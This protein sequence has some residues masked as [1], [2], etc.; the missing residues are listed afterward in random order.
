MLAPAEYEGAPTAGY[1]STAT[2]GLPPKRTFAA[3]H[4]TI[5]GWRDWRDWMRWE[6]DGEACRALFAGLVG[7]R[8]SD[9]ALVSALSVA[10]GLVAASLPAGPGDNIVSY[11]DDF[12]SV[13]F[14]F[15]ALESRGVEIRLVPLE[16]LADAVDDRTALVA[17]STVQSATG[18]VADLDALRATGARLFVDATQSAGALPIDVSGIDY[19]GVAAYKWM[20]CPRGLA[21]FY[22]RPERLQEI[23]PWLAGWKSAREAYHHY[24]GPPRELTDDARRLDVSLAWFSAAGGR[25]SLELLTELGVD[26]I[27]AHDLALA[28]RFCAGLGLPAP[29]SPIVRLSVPDAERTLAE[30]ESAG[31]R[32]AGR[33]GAVRLSFHLY[34]T[35]A[36]VDRALEVLGS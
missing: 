2:Y 16:R 9:I 30:L 19:L 20:L 33:A 5:D 22:V 25:T 17:V 29:A 23:E 32:G 12:H 24:Y 11:E 1:L 21:F 14:P 10:S 8:A 27:G 6:E 18:A 26:R 31:I 28:G 34:N 35:D 13:L 4:D 36:D 15:L 3:M 7:A